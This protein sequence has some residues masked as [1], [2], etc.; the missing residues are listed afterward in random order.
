MMIEREQEPV[1]SRP[2][3]PLLWE[4]SVEDEGTV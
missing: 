4:R 3:F 1:G 2:E